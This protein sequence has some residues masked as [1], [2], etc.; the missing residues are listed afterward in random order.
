LVAASATKVFEPLVFWIV[1]WLPLL[2]GVNPDPPLADSD[3]YGVFE[4][5]L[6]YRVIPILHTALV[7]PKA[8][9]RL[10]GQIN[11]FG[12]YRAVLKPGNFHSPFVFPSRI[13][14]SYVRARVLHAAAY[15]YGPTWHCY[16]VIM[17]VIGDKSARMG[18]AAI[19]YYFVGALSA[20]LSA[21]TAITLGLVHT[22]LT[23]I[24]A[25]GGMSTRS[26]GVVS[27]I[28]NAIRT[29]VDMLENNRG[30][31]IYTLNAW[32]ARFTFLA[33]LPSWL[34]GDKL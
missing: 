33:P 8:N 10:E 32:F 6:V 9:L 16:T 24:P 4:F 18:V 26:H 12:L 21:A 7:F 31:Y 11:D 3:E 28:S 15:Y 13:P 20:T 25:I 17:D 14:L 29:T 22:T 19:P 30:D 27:M 5:V 1:N 2:F 34:A 23:A